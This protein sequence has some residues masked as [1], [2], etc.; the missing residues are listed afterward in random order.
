VRESTKEGV[1]L[2]VSVSSVA[3]PHGTTTNRSDL[4]PRRS[5]RASLYRA[6]VPSEGHCEKVRMITVMMMTVTY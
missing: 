1:T 4:T 2:W 6:P 5:T 3:F